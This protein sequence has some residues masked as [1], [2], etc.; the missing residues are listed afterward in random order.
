MAQPLHAAPAAAAPLRP[1]ALV[2]M[3]RRPGMGRLAVVVVILV[4]W[5]IGG[6]ELDPQFFSSP[7]RTVAAFGAMMATPGLKPALLLTFGELCAAFAI[8]VT[9]GTAIG[10]FVGLNRFSRRSVLPII[11]FLYGI[12]QVTI[13]PLILLA[14]GIGPAA[15]ITFGATHA[16]FPIMLTVAAGVQNIDPSLLKSA[17][18]LGAS[19]WQ[20]FRYVTF[21]HMVPSFFAG[22]RLSMVLAILGVLLAEL[23]VTTNGVGY[24][25]RTF[26]DNFQAPQL[27]G[28]VGLLAAMAVL[29]NELLRRLEL[30]FSRW[31]T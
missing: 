20:V 12:P 6:F 2:R 23:Y 8:A 29:L 4:L 16:I 24:F 15:K 22:V 27:F 21:P 28:L 13:L 25:T 17:R 3:L 9:A 10:L 5:E 18:S 1:G 26:T 30:R 14:A 11:L 31:R 19:R 7:A